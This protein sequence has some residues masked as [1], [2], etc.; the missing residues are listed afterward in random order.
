MDSSRFATIFLIRHGETAWNKKG[1]LQGHADSPLTK[2][3]IRKAIEKASI[4]KNVNFEA[5][6]SSDLLRAVRTAEIL[7]LDRELKIVSKKALR[8]RS[9]GIYDGKLAKEFEKKIRNMLEE[10]NRLPREEKLRFRFAS[11]YESDEELISRFITF[12]RE[13]AISFAGKNVLVV[14]HGGTIKTFLVHCGYIELEDARGYKFEN[15]G[16]VRLESDGV[17]FFIKEVH[18]LKKI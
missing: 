6:F 7:R 18:G 15:S 11:G 14:S 8:E 2:E 17:E 12:L 9:Y 10:Y 16:H 3:G 1:L 5:I 13:I 4:L